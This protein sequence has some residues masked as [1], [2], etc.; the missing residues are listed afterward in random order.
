MNG[1][2][3]GSRP[4]SWTLLLSGLLLVTPFGLAGSTAV[5][6]GSL[7]CKTCH[8]EIYEAWTTSHHYRSMAKST[9]R[10]VLGNFDGEPLEFH[11]IRSRYYKKDGRFYIETD[12]G[13]GPRAFPIKYTFGH[14]PL[15]QYLVELEKGQIQALNI[16]WDARPEEAGGGRWMHLQPA[17]A[18]SVESPF[19]WTSHF[20]NWNAR[21]AEC[22]STGVDVNY[23]ESN[24]RFETTFAEINVACE[25]C[26]GPGKQHIDTKG[27]PGTI[28][29]APRELAW[30]FMEGDPTANPSGGR[31]DRMVDMCGG[32]HSRRSLAVTPKVG[33]DYHGQYRIA[34][35]EAGL[36]HADGQINDEVFV[37]G[38]FLQSKM[39]AQGVTCTNCHEPHTGQLLLQGNDLCAQCHNP[40]VFDDGS[41]HFH[42]AEEEKR[43]L[44]VDCHMPQKTYM[45]VDDRAD[46]R[47]G[48]PH[49]D[50]RSD[51]PSACLNCHQVMPLVRGEELAKGAT[52]ASVNTRL[53]QGDPLVL[54]DALKLLNEG[55]LPEIQQATILN[56]LTELMPIELIEDYVSHDSP[57]VRRV[58]A[59]ALAERPF[60]QAYPLLRRLADDP[61]S[62]VRH[63]AARALAGHLEDIEPREKSFFVELIDE[64]RKSLE[65]TEYS[66]GTLTELARLEISLGRFR[67][68]QQAHV[69]ALSIEPNY[70][71]AMLNHADLERALGDEK[72]AASVLSRAVAFAPDSAAANFSFGL[73][74]VRR[75]KMPEALGYLEQATK[76]ADAIPRYAY[77]YAVALDSVGRTASAVDVLGDAAAT[78]PN[79]YDLLWLQVL[80]M[81]KSGDVSG[82]VDPLRQLLRLNP[83]Q[84]AV[85]HRLEHHRNNNDQGRSD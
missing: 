80:F 30:R 3:R 76:Q 7:T 29:N 34:L 40:E 2:G 39:Y 70:L 51:L 50:P 8:E 71:P 49:L 28:F 16:A 54:D 83:G 18:T 6:V 12:V 52:Y 46:H 41:H 78:W 60:V 55:S 63:N 4:Y 82:I 19:F 45:L 79:Q 20:Q 31:S 15:Q 23:D 48:V 58:V 36:Y 69:R 38:S 57:I 81:E 33:A 61:V 27:S 84:P 72:T 56:G 65:L 62:T 14:S 21:C 25:A 35:L 17:E 73:S 42:A 10:T 67:Q 53:R 32:C 5:H 22:H 74:L 68:G 44:C 75:Q 47:F 9:E 66:P 37:L 77:V 13:K 1:F 26:H 24:H 43:P 64:Y 59:L 85:L 11:G